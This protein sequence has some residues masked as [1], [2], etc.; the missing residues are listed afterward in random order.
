MREKYDVCLSRAAA[1]MV[2]FGAWDDDEAGGAE[3]NVDRTRLYW[4]GT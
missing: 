4:D 1:R 3:P 2:M